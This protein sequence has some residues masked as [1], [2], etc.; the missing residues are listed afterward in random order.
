MD[1]D[2]LR[3]AFDQQTAGYD[4]QWARMAQFRDGLHFLLESVLA[5][6]PVGARILGVGAGTGAEL[7]HLAQMNPH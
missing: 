4:K 2:E 5:E 1:R 3:T 7:I 6:L